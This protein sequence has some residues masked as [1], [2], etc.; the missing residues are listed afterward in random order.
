VP[1]LQFHTAGVRVDLDCPDASV[2]DLVAAVGASMLARENGAAALTVRAAQSGSD[3][4]DSDRL[5]GDRM[6]GVH[7]D[8]HPADDHPADD[9]SRAAAR[10]LAKVDRAALR[11]TSCLTVHAAVLAGPDGCVVIPGESGA[12]KSTLA[13]AAMQ[14]G[15][16]LLSDEAA[17]FTEPVGTLVPHPRPLGLS[18]ASRRL[19]GIAD[20]EDPSHE[21]ATAPSLLGRTAAPSSTGHCVLVALLDRRW[22]A[23]PR[24]DHLSP[25]DALPGLFASCLNVPPTDAA[26]WQ[27]ADAW[28]YLSQLA[29]ITRHARLTF[30]SPY[31]GAR[32][33]A[34]ALGA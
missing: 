21:Q 14:C 3:R 24:L 23:E 29:G 12:G 1:L 8:G 18:P 5:D 7:A 2:S 32:L 4:L 10:L 33:L 6:D 13:G 26:G 28:R 31:D 25:A 34:T 16:T 27:P 9:V 22:G 11:L 15:L 20:A 17:C 30:D 19:L